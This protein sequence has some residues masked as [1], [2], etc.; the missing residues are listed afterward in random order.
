MP[1]SMRQSTSLS[2]AWPYLIIESLRDREQASSVCRLLQGPSLHLLGSWSFESLKMTFPT[3]VHLQKLGSSFFPLTET[4]SPSHFTQHSWIRPLERQYLG[5]IPFPLHA[6]FRGHSQTFRLW[7]LLSKSPSLQAKCSQALQLFLMRWSY[8]AT[9]HSG[10]TVLDM[11][12]VGMPL[13]LCSK[14][15]SE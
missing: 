15:D 9:R 3:Q 2:P 10:C 11:F 12:Q 14:Q 1:S 7:S 13:F 8:R 4:L 5:L 6:V